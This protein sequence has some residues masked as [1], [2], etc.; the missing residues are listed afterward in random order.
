MRAAVLNRL[1]AIDRQ[2]KDDER[3][4]KNFVA[5]WNY[6][7]DRADLDACNAALNFQNLA[8]KDRRQLESWRI[9][10]VARVQEQQRLEAERQAALA[11]K[12]Q[13]DAEVQRQAEWDRQQQAQ[14]QADEQRSAE[15][16]RMTEARRQTEA[17]RIRAEQE[18]E[19]NARQQ[20]KA[21][22]EKADEQRRLAEMRASEAERFAVQQ[23][24]HEPGRSS[25]GPQPFTT[26][27]LDRSPLPVLSPYLTWLLLRLTV[28]SI[29]VVGE[30]RLCAGLATDFSSYLAKSA[31]K[32]AL[33]L[34]EA[35]PTPSPP[36]EPGPE[37]PRAIDILFP[38]T[39][40]FPTDVRRA[41][42]G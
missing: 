42:A 24:N 37:D 16:E 33:R 19:A 23:A 40:H 30:W 12:Q 28:A 35:L 18:R 10:I 9:T 39:G 7:R 2:R 27:S 22:A 20:A 11:Q 14:R 32:Y 8:S 36:T 26:G 6:C 4:R 31:S 17:A 34:K 5:N 13:Q 15:Q 1:S 41:L 29:F 38:L 25:A 21:G 3:A